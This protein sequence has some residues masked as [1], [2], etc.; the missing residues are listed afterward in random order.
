MQPRMRVEP[1]VAER[2][3]AVHRQGR[4]HNRLR[5]WQAYAPH[6]TSELT[7]KS[8]T[9]TEVPVCSGSRGGSTPRAETCFGVRRRR[10]AV[11][12]ARFA[13]TLPSPLF[14]AYSSW[15]GRCINTARRLNKEWRHE[16]WAGG[17]QPANGILRV[18]IRKRE[19]G[20]GRF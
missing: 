11:S 4:S 1:T 6:G 3:Y 9:R 5:Q 10:Q 14:S 8:F 13:R 12:E 20:I 19:F 7:I 16:Q 15:R 2:H 18:R 17:V